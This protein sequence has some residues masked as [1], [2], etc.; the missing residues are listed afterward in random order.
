MI[1]DP[2]LVNGGDCFSHWHSSDRQPT[3]DFL[4]GLQ[5]LCRVKEASAN[6][7]ASL[8]D[9]YNLV[10]T[11]GGAVI[12]ILPKARNNRVITFTKVGGGN[13]LTLTTTS[14]DTINGG[15][16]L[17]I[18]SNYAPVRLLARQGIGYVQV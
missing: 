15:A 4:E 2:S 6:Y 11:S 8:N 1:D 3:H 14:P 17:V 9:D 10:T 13:T 12:V 7:E 16:S 18:S 5:T